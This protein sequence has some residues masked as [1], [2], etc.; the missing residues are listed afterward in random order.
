MCFQIILKVI[1]H[2]LRFLTTS[3]VPKKIN[4]LLQTEID[5]G[6]H[7]IDLRLQKW[8]I[9]YY[10]ALLEDTRKSYDETAKAFRQYYDEKPVVLRG[11]LA[12]RFQGPGEKLTGF[13]G[14]LQT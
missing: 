2:T 9:D 10:H 7:F 13:N 14:D 3:E 4:K 8:A 6:P 5:E 12:R 11:R 1:L